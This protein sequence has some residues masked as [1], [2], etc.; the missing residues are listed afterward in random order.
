MPD[1]Q[2]TPI[3]RILTNNLQKPRTENPMTQASK[4][5]LS[6]QDLFLILPPPSNAARKPAQVT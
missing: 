4:H 6:Q 3:H 2:P 1:P 5:S